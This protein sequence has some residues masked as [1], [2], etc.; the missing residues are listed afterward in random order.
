MDLRRYTNLIII[1]IK[2]GRWSH[3]HNV[4]HLLH[5]CGI[6][7]LAGGLKSKIA[8]TAWWVFMAKTDHLCAAAAAA[9]IILFDWS[10]YL[11]L[12]HFMSVP[13]GVKLRWG[14]YKCWKMS[15]CRL[16]NLLYLRN[17]RREAHNYNGTQRGRYDGIV[18]LNV[19]LDT[20]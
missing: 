15:H 7:A 18:G 17:N 2:G 20:L 1:I 4:M 8:A 9:A 19:P 10:I 16:N 11:E 3:T 5:V 12:L 14:R 6:A 13:L